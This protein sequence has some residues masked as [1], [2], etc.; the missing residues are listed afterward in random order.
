M[1]DQQDDHLIERLA[2]LQPIKTWSLLVTIFGDMHRAGTPT[3]S[4]PFIKDLLEP[5]GIRPE[6]IRVAL[7]RLRKDGWITTERVGRETLYRLSENALTETQSAYVD[8]YRSDVKFADGWLL[9]TF[10][11]AEPELDFG[12]RISRMSWLVPSTKAEHLNGALISQVDPA[13]IPDWVK[14]S[15]VSEQNI[16]IAEQLCFLAEAAIENAAGLPHL[17]SGIVRILILHHWRRMALRDETWFHIWQDDRGAMARSQKQVLST[18]EKM[19]SVAVP[20]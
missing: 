8:V 14:N 19:Q 20:A 18:L 17:N 1:T 16:L 11:S 3:L 12:L 10:E 6:A 2:S 5:I 13:S 7:H 4:G 15:V 9:A